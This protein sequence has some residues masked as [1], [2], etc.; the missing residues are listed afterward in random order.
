M[1]IPWLTSSGILLSAFRQRWGK[2]VPAGRLTF[3][4]IFVIMICIFD[5]LTTLNETTNR[6]PP[7]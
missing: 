2:E 1:P 3:S 5:A 6:I 4:P 7:R